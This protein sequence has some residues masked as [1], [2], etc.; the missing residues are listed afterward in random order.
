MSQ[1][2][3]LEELK[4][5][6]EGRTAIE[7]SD[8]LNS[9]KHEVQGEIRMLRK[10]FI[11][12]SQIIPDSHHTVRYVLKGVKYDHEHFNRNKDGTEIKGKVG[13]ELDKHACKTFV[14]PRIEDIDIKGKE[15]GLSDDIIK[16]AKDLAIEYFKKTYQKPE[17]Y[18]MNR[19]I[20]AFIL[21]ATNLMIDENGNRI[22]II[23]SAPGIKTYL[24]IIFDVTISAINKWNRHICK[25]LDI[26]RR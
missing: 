6:P 20:P 17:Y 12:D 5:H 13:K 9:P 8:S 4:K 24:A 26:E 21:I 19:I 14:C 7:L 22:Y 3:V 23:N 18:G 10:S 16:L 2:D 15:L 11:I 1:I 25:E